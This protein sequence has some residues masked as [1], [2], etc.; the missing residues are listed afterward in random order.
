MNMEQP[1]V[2]NQVVWHWLDSMRSLSG[3]VAT[4]SHQS[5]SAT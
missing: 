5:P 3:A 1:E 4:G 2:F